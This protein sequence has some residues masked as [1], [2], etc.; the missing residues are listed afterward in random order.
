MMTLKNAGVR[1]VCLTL[2][3]ACGGC[4]TAPLITAQAIDHKLQRLELGT[5]RDTVIRRL[6]RPQM[7]TFIPQG[8]SEYEIYTYQL[9]NYTHLEEQMLILKDGRLCAVP[10]SPEDLLRF[11]A[12]SGLIDRRSRFWKPQGE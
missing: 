4:G 1:A 10:R 11:M 9:G 6:G 5:S 7:V 2:A 8:G 12:V 3:L